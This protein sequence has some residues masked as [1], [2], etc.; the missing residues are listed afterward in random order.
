MDSTDGFRVPSKTRRTEQF[1]LNRPKRVPL[2]SPATQWGNR[3]IFRA[4]GTT[5]TVRACKDCVTRPALTWLCRGAVGMIALLLICGPAAAAGWQ[6]TQLRGIVLSLEG[7]T[8]SDLAGGAHLPDHITLRTLGRS[9]AEFTGTGVS[10]PS[11][12]APPPNSPSSA[13]K[14]MWCCMPARSTSTS[15]RGMWSASSP[16]GQHHAG[17]GTG[18][19]LARRRGHACHRRRG[20]P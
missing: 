15:P 2:F 13:P 19:D 11:R 4:R 16:P 6:A 20:Q 5:T 10:L 7:E 9:E 3:S 8:W 17:A 12:T 1:T 14:S 18:A